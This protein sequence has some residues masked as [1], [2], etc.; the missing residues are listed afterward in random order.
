MHA[1]P[2]DA[3]QSELTARVGR[4]VAALAA[5]VIHAV[6]LYVQLAIGPDGRLDSQAV[7]VV[8]D[9]VANLAL[10]SRLGRREEEILNVLEGNLDPKP[11]LA[12]LRDVQ[13]S[14]ILLASERPTDWPRAV[15]KEQILRAFREA[16]VADFVSNVVGANARARDGGTARDD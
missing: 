5:S 3:E 14:L 1:N 4:V 16:P 9:E 15:S 7:D 8:N 13:D 10:A 12:L 2:Q 6:A 11:A